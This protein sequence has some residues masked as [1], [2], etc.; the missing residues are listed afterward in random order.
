[1]GGGERGYGREGGWTFM[2][3]G[4]GGRGTHGGGGWG[5]HGTVRGWGNLDRRRGMDIHDSGKG[6]GHPG[7]K[8]VGHS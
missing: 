4:E 1:M 7:G 3:G 8:G 6:A 2:T 5:T